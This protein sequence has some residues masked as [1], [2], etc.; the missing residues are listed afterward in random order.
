MVGPVNEPVVAGSAEY[1]R[2]FEQ[3][4]LPHL[5]AMHRLAVRLV[6]DAAAAEDLVQETYLKAYRSFGSLR[7]PAGA[8][9]WLCRILGRLAI[10]SHRARRREVRVEDVEELDG[11]SLYER[12]WDED[13]QPYSDR[14]HDDFLAQF[15]DEE[16]RAALQALPDSYRIPLVLLYIEESACTYRELAEVIGCPIGTVMSR[17]HR[18][19]KILERELWE[20]ARRR[21]LVKT[22]QPER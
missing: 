13:P 11:F 2:R 8:R 7:D 16:V 21:G 4:M 5:A 15:Q 19:R 12:I 3:L 10:D 20:C 17:L 22:W 18:G 14:P 6:N 1:R 9:S